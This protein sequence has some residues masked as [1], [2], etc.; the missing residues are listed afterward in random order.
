MKRPDLQKKRIEV[1]LMAFRDFRETGPC[2]QLPKCVPALVLN[3]DM[4]IRSEWSAV[5]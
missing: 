1:L 4:T 5:H 3:S 2:K